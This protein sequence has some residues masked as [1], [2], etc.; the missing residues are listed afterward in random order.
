MERLKN[1]I[2][3][4][5]M[6]MVN[7]SSNTITMVSDLGPMESNLKPGT[8]CDF[9]MLPSGDKEVVFKSGDRVIGT[10]SRKFDPEKPYTVVLADSGN[11]VALYVIDDEMR[12]PTAS[13][14]LKTYY[15]GLA[16]AAPSVTI[17]LTSSDQSYTI[18]PGTGE[19]KLAAGSY[20]VSGEG[21]TDTHE[22]SVENRGMYSLFV[23]DAA[24][25]KR[26]AY[27]IQNNPA[28]VPQIG[29]QAQT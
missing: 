13:T 24:D 26:F 2:P 11:G 22:L 5:Q 15:V 27:L 23:V 29:G 19:I 28:Q 16:G 8:F 17:T 10:I 21:V 20:T 9:R 12:S 25:G 6:R 1:T 3:P 4:A 7:L 18:R 14:N